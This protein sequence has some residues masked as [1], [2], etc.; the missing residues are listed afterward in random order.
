MHFCDDFIVNR[1]Q[2]GLH[3]ADNEAIRPV[4]TKS[5]GVSMWPPSVM[6]LRT[7]RRDLVATWRQVLFRNF[8]QRQGMLPGYVASRPLSA[9]RLFGFQPFG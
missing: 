4:R 7:M 5:G 2:S 1:Q 3:V 6:I 9:T 8:A